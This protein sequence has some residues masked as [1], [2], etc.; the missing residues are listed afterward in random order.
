[1]HVLIVNAYGAAADVGGTEKGLGLLTRN[2]VERG[3]EVSILQA[4]PGA[5][6]PGIATTVLHE[7]DGR[8]SQRRRVG[9]HIGDVLSHPTRAVARAVDASKPDVV[10]THNLQGLGTGVWEISRRRGT[11]VFHT[12]HDYHLL[13]PRVTLMRANGEPCRPHPAL[14]GFRAARLARWA[15]AVSVLAGVSDF[16]VRAHDGVFPAIPRHV[17]RNPMQIDAARPL[18]PPSRSLR[19]IGYIG[20]LSREKG[21][22]V[23]LRAASALGERG[24]ELRI[25]GGGRLEEDVAEAAR[26]TPSVSLHGV[27]KG[28][29]KWEFLEG[30][31]LGVVPSVWAEPGGPTHTIVEWL[32]AGR[33]TL[34]SPRGGLGEI[35]GDCPGA[36]AVE[37]T[38]KGIVAAVDALLD[39]GAWAAAVERVR[40][41]E[42]EGEVERWMAQNLDVYRS[43]T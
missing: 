11:P 37:P 5:Q 39:P 20:N 26:T 23:L 40:P 22:D 42:S 14:C 8:T 32:G 21:V 13:C 34:V 33:P 25:A 17:I 16:L 28:E 38:V 30:C 2:L 7:S 1:V 19:T 29:G 9:N 15:G 4:F 6:L 35:I 24:L 27:V 43:L 3:I 31:D 10:H 36:I 41:V 18:R 12:L